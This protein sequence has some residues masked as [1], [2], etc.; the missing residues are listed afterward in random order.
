MLQ[1]PGVDLC[2]LMGEAVTGDDSR[3]LIMLAAERLR[4]PDALTRPRMLFRVSIAV[5]HFLAR[6]WYPLAGRPAALAGR[7]S[8]RLSAR[9]VSSVA[10]RCA[11][12]ADVRGSNPLPP[13][14]AGG[15]AR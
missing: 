6:A 11:Y 1:V 4:K 8:N 14:L 3:R 9:A 12:N 13:T 7:R 10:E 5:P 2:P 15:M